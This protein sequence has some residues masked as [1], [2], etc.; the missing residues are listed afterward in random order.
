MLPTK[1][2]STVMLHVGWIL[3]VTAL[4]LAAWGS[5]AEPADLE[6]MPVRPIFHSSALT[7]ATQASKVQNG[8]F[9]APA[10]WTIGADWNIAAGVATKAATGV[11]TLSQTSVN[12]LVVGDVYLVTYTITV[13]GVTTGGLTPSICGRTLANVA[14]AGTYRDYVRCTS[15]ADLV[16]TPGNALSTLTLD[17]VSVQFVA[18][19]EA[20]QVVAWEEDSN[21][22]AGQGGLH[23]MD[24]GG[25]WYRIGGG[26]ISGPDG[27][28]AAPTFSWTNNPTGG[29]YTTG[30]GDIGIAVSS[31]KR[32]R[33]TGSTFDLLTDAMVLRFGAL[34]DVVLGREAAAV[35]QLGGD[36][37][38]PATQKLKG[39]D[40]TGGGPTVGGILQLQG[41]APAG[42]AAYG[43]VAIPNGTLVIDGDY[44]AITKRLRTSIAQLNAGV[45]LL[46]AVASMKYRL[47]DVTAIAYGATCLGATTVTL[48][49]N[50]GGVVTLVS[51]P[52]ATLIQ[53]AVLKPDTA[54]VAVL[55]DGA[56][57]VA[58]T[59]NT[60]F[61]AGK[62]GGNVT[63]C[64]G[65]DFSLTYTK[66][67]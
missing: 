38:A 23:V 9:A 51:Y 22:V 58:N 52:I 66:E 29:W 19:A 30:T 62:T 21:G 6:G 60:S 31:V 47:V 3:A 45:V 11:T 33:F 10:G 14:A 12:M 43:N 13:F 26:Q 42:A 24:E 7:N 27:S 4:C 15:T 39:A 57:F 41:G 1:R 50:Q 18:H 34:G 61:S 54:T 64:T 49:G 28:V 8:D 16:F 35:L 44:V 63:T 37:A 65:V 17:N 55:P 59:A 20:D 2:E 46:P 40:A 25:A 67:P 36:A 5:L 56:S 32:A 48:L 53:S